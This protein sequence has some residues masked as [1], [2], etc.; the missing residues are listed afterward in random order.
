MRHYIAGIRVSDG[1]YSWML[2]QR[3]YQRNTSRLVDRLVD[4]HHKRGLLSDFKYGFSS[5]K[6]IAELLTIRV[7]ALNRSGAT[8]PVALN[9]SKSFDRVW[10]DDLLQKLKSCGVSVQIFGYISSFLSN[11]QLQEVLDRKS[12]QKYPVNTGVPQGS[13]LGLTLFLLYINDFPDVMCN[14]AI[15][16][17]D[18][19][20]FWKSGQA[21]DWW[22][23]LEM[24]NLN[25]IYKRHY[26][27]GQKVTYWF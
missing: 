13:I 17:D 19:T 21:S 4:H 15:Y 20:L 12:L 23:Q 9:I 6:S 18:T 25:L 5:S 1:R 27:L 14:I 24:W 8:R 11:R 16:A 2:Y 26:G 22:K 3:L 7:R 10:H